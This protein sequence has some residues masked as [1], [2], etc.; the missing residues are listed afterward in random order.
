MNKIKFNKKTMLQA[1]E[2]SY[3][4]ST[5]LADWLVKILHYPFRQAYNITG[6]IVDYA[7]SKNKSLSNMS[8][9]E[10]QKF[11]TNI[12]S[13]IFSVLSSLNSMQSKNSFGGSA[14][15]TVKKS[16]QYMIKKYL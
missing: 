15:E 13:D 1:V 2:G 11:D 5:D 16:I 9:K 12:T 4:S 8:L 14:P 10:L 7:Y 6:K 3:A